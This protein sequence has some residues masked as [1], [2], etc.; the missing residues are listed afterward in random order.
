MDVLIAVFPLPAF[1][2]LALSH[3]CCC[4]LLGP[5]FFLLMATLFAS[6]R[7]R[8]RRPVQSVLAA[9]TGH[10]I[11]LAIIGLGVLRQAPLLLFT[12]VEL[13]APHTS[14]VDWQPRC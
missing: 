8:R 14:V 9:G 11:M 12:V 13:L 5:D 10:T 4:C 3:F 7:A 2:A 1:P 6:A